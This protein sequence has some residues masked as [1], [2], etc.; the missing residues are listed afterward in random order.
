MASVAPDLSRVD[1][2][3]HGTVR[4][5][6]YYRCRCQECRSAWATYRME[7]RN[8]GVDARPVRTS[9]RKVR[10]DTGLSNTER[11]QTRADRRFAALKRH[12]GRRVQRAFRFDDSVAVLFGEQV[13]W[14]G[15]DGRWTQH[16]PTADPVGDMAV[17]L[18][19]IKVDNL[20]TFLSAAKQCPIVPSGLVTRALAGELRIIIEDEGPRVVLMKQAT[21]I[22]P[23]E[24]G[25]V[26]TPTTIISNAIGMRG[27]SEHGHKG[28]TRTG[29][30][31]H[32]S[33]SAKGRKTKTAA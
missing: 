10:W 19:E 3:H 31:G 13:A 6:S 29:W 7:R 5:Y 27:H 1:E 30:K 9:T 25:E 26:A 22:V 8:N 32:V 16:Q 12:E 11:V 21:D 24:G 4:G 2:G 15:R 23:W 17:T 14:R 18:A 20:E 28:H 33:Q